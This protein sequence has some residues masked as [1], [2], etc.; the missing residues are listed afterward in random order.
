MLTI[1][2]KRERLLDQREATAREALEATV[3][4]LKVS[5]EEAEADLYQT[6]VKMGEDWAKEMAAFPELCNLERTRQA[7]PDFFAGRADAPPAERASLPHHPQESTEVTPA[8]KLWLSL[9]PHAPFWPI[10]AGESRAGMSATWWSEVLGGSAH[11]LTAEPMFLKGFI[12]GAWSVW[13]EVRPLVA[14]SS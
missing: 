14:A 12:E 11:L 7:L 10:E 3:E 13:T 9:H 5:K 2:R 8:M 4:R 6:G 1:E